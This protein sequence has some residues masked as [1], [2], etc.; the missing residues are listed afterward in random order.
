MN[1]KTFKNFQ[2]FI[3]FCNFDNFPNCKSSEMRQFFQFEQYIIEWIK[4]NSDWP[5]W[6]S[7]T[8]YNL[9]SYQIFSNVQF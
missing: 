7:M 6:E 1:R 2:N 5:I 9:E 8:I 3:I 4:K